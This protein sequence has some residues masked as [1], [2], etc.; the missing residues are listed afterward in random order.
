MAI[1]IETQIL[2]IRKWPLYIVAAIFFLWIF[3]AFDKPEH[4]SVK[5][6]FFWGGLTIFTLVFYLLSKT[7]IRLD[8]EEIT[9][10]RFSSKSTA[11][12][13]KEIRLSELN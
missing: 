1:P 5:S 7:E 10:T 6:Y 2:K 9:V 8:N 13:W 4:R 11:I 12:K 3:I